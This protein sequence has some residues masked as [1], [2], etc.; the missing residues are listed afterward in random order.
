M[1]SGVTRAELRAAG[2][3]LHDPVQRRHAGL[4]FAR[5]FPLH[6][7]DVELF[8]TARDLAGLPSPAI[9]EPQGVDD[10]LTR[11]ELL[12][13]GMTARGL[14]DA[15]KTGRLIRLRNGHYATPAV[16][17]HLQRAVRFGGRVGCVSEL[18]L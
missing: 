9:L 2:T 12:A 18:H 16:E 3:K 14:T 11:A 8:S 7:R 1:P 6:S 4:S 15:V 5:T 17:P 13:A 10:A